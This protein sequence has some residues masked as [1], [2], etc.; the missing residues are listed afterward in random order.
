MRKDGAHLPLLE[1]IPNKGIYKAFLF[2]LHFSAENFIIKQTYCL[3]IIYYNTFLRKRE[4]K[5]KKFRFFP[6]IIIICLA[7]SC[8]APSASAL[9]EPS[10]V[11]TSVVLADLNSDA[12]LYSKNMD[13]QVSPASLTKI[14]TVLIAIEEVE[15]G[16]HSLDESVTA[17]AGCRDGM[18]EDSST[19]GITPGETMSYRDLIYCAMLQSA[20]EACNILA[21][22][23]SGSVESFVARMNE[24]AAALGCT[25][26]HFA[27][28]NGLTND[29]H[30]TTAYDFSLITREAVKHEFFMTVVNTKQ[31]TVPQTNYCAPRVLENSNALINT[32]SIYG[33]DYF[34]EYASGVKTGYTRA[35]GS[36]LISTAEKDGVRLLGVVMGSTCPLNDPNRKDYGNFVDSL[37]LYNWGFANFSYQTVVTT[38]MNVQSVS[39]DLAQ[40]FSEIMLHPANDVTLLLPNDTDVSQIYLNTTIYA[41]ELVAPISSGQELG[42]ASI[43]IN[44]TNYGTV[45]LV[46]NT[47]V[48]LSRSE[49]FKLRLQSLF[50][51]TWVVVLI[52]FVCLLF[53]GY[54]ALVAHYR[55][56]RQKHLR[57]R[58]MAEQRRS[59]QQYD[60]PDYSEYSPNRTS[61]PKPTPRGGSY[62]KR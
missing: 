33:S 23:V 20:N 14:M 17:Q 2:R 6:L 44:G 24:R 15:A 4:N 60:R 35:A 43:M 61:P 8:I 28:T 38:A 25:G 55:R 1:Q 46:S 9:D 59:M 22:Q 57:Q 50:G 34:Y 42:T 11:A 26:T 41:D 54:L 56:L 13:A 36:C 31:Y 16:N 12:V 45:K 27:N 29:A 40:D 21:F 52:V 30:Y 32:A 5:M 49:Y 3:L 62:T 19:S 53:V 48:D 39:I 47:S 51:K 10:M 58:R 37:S 7:L 18:D